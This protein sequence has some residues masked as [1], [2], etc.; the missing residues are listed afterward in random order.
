MARMTL[1]KYLLELSI[2][3]LSLLLLTSVTMCPVY[4]DSESHG[5]KMNKAAYRVTTHMEKM[6]QNTKMQGPRTALEVRQITD[7][8]VSQIEQQLQDG[9]MRPKEA[10]SH[11]HT[12]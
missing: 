6:R 9:T 11:C 2:F 4:A 10:C 8:E 7:V 5:D 12:N 3:L 1:A